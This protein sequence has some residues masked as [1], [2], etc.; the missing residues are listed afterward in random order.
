MDF[1]V[2]LGAAL[3]A[4]ERTLGFPHE[5]EAFIP[6][7]DEGPIGIVLAD[8]G[9]DLEPARQF[10]EQFDVVV[11]VEVRR[12]T[13]LDLGFKLD[14]VEQALVAVLDLVEVSADTG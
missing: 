6:F 1:L 14:G 12:E 10:D 7:S 3:L 8:G 5:I 4:V 13:A 11:G 9:V 2:F